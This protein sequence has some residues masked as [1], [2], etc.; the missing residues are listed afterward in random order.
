MATRERGYWSII[1]CLLILCGCTQ[2]K[3]TITYKE[4]RLLFNNGPDNQRLRGKTII[5]TDP[6]TVLKLLSF[7]PRMGQGRSSNIVAG[8]ASRVSIVF[9]DEA[10]KEVKVASN[11]DVWSEGDG[12][13]PMDPGFS[14]YISDL[15]KDN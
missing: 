8:C 14:S 1:L 5:V 10:G 6:Q 2:P 12:D 11:Y 15:L 13:W 7:F 9:V 3:S 4:A